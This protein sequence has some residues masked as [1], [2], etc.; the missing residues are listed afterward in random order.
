[1][2]FWLYQ[3]KRHFLQ[4]N[5][6]ETFGKPMKQRLLSVA[7]WM[8]LLG[9]IF[10]VPAIALAGLTLGVSMPQFAALKQNGIQ[11]TASVVQKLPYRSLC[12]NRTCTPYALRLSFLTGVDSQQSVD[13]LGVKITLPKAFVGTLQFANLTVSESEYNKTNL[14]DLRSIVFLEGNPET[15]WRTETVLSWTPWGN[16]LGAAILL[17]AGGICLFISRQ[18]RSRQ[19]QAVT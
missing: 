18:W 4:R 6:W 12:E 10:I 17:I 16:L 15:I 5:F 14:G 9:A 13:V 19:K 2:I 7:E 8:L 11:K 3:V 1:L